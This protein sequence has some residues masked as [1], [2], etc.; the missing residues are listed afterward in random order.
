VTPRRLRRLGLLVT[1][2]ALGAVQVRSG[3]AQEVPAPPYYALLPANYPYPLIRVCYTPAGICAV[4]HT[5]MPGRPCA[6]QRPDGTWVQGVC[7]H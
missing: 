6:C 5:I 7:T 4:P 3:G 1:G 2:L